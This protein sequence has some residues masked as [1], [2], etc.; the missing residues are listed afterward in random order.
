[1]ERREDDHHNSLQHSH[2]VIKYAHMKFVVWVEL[3][4][5]KAWSIY[6]NPPQAPTSLA[7]NLII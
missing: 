7:Q 2:N 6:G 5:R 4:Q 1:M 3:S